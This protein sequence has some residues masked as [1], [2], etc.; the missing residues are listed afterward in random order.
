MKFSFLIANY[1]NGKYFKECFDSII[2]QTYKNWEAIIVDDAS[3]DNSV[4][5]I[6]ELIKDDPRFILLKNEVNKGCGFT[7]RKTLEHATG[8]FCGFLDPDDAV[9]AHAV[10]RSLSEYTSDKIVG[11]YSKIMFC[12]GDLKPVSDYKKIK[13]VYNDKYF[14]NCPIQMNAFFTF[15]KSAYD[16]TEGI[17]PELKSAVDQDLYLKVLEHGNPIFIK[18]NMYLYRRHSMG[19]SQD[20]S[21][22]KAKTNFAKVIFDALKRRNIKAVNGQKVPKEFTDPEEI[23]NLLEY[24]NSIPYRLKQKIRLFFRSH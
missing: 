20:S 7:K 18:E 12:D 17:N 4:E 23:Y 9:T 3:T 1:N 5:I 16:K 10:E 19:I 11:T 2:A 8:E 22:S 13:Q 6:S 21:K 14:F 15:R 24:Q